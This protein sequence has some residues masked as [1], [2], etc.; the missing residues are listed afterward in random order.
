M[1]ESRSTAAAAQSSVALASEPARRR[2]RPPSNRSQEA[3]LAAAGELLRE[4]GL[5]ALTVD[6]VVAQAKVSKGTVYRLWD[7]KSAIAIDAILRVL[8]REIITPDTGSAKEDFRALM[9]QFADVLQRG[10][11]GYTYI[12]LLIEAQQDNRIADIHQRL[13]RERRSVFFKV[14]AKGIQRGELPPDVDN[15]LLSDMLFGP[16][17]L[18]LVTGVGKVDSS[19]IDVTLEVVYRGL[20]T[21]PSDGAS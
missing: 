2:G 4:G 9:R 10:G 19:M 12:S 3:I 13:F 6:A 14:V 20:S 8:N 21:S 18:R 17:V 15:D 16:T 7:T 11:L 1:P 5:A